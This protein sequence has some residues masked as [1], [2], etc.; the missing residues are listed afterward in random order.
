M[1]MPNASSHAIERNLGCSKQPH[2][3]GPGSLNSLRTAGTNGRL[4]FSLSWRI[5]GDPAI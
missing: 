1:K 2:C 4:H 5:A 3:K